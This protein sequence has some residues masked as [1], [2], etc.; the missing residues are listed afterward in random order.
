MSNKEHWEKI[1]TTK[2]PHEVSWTQEVP[3]TSLTLIAEL[4]LDKNASIIDI[5]GGDSY[6]VDHLLDLG[7]TNLSV[8]DISNAAIDRAKIRLGEK[9]NMVEWIVSDIVEF[10]PNRSY[11]LWH[12]RAVFHFL[13]TSEDILTYKQLVTNHAK[14]VVLGT[15]AKDG[16]I[17]CSGLEIT[18]YDKASINET[19]KP[20]FSMINFLTQTHTTPFN[21]TQNFVF[22]SLKNQL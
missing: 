16:P 5:G 12:D 21:T 11:D 6:L 2:Q 9:A 1:Y 19:F 22:A 8:L 20:G 3:E 13:N 15:F 14:N 17:K 10:V 7:Y 4:K 18:Q